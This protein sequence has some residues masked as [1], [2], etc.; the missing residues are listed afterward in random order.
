ME[1]EFEHKFR[2]G[3]SAEE[4]LAWAEWQAQRV[5]PLGD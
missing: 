1:A 3:Q 2:E 4:R 5:H